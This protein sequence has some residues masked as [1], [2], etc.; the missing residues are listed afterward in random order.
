MS[1][2]GG[3]EGRRRVLFVHGPRNVGGDT[4]AILRLIEGLDRDVIDPIVVA[5]PAGAAWARFVEL[6]GAGRVRLHALEMGVA[7]TEHEAPAVSTGTQARVVATRS[8]LFDQ[9]VANVIDY[10]T[11]FCQSRLLLGL[12]YLADM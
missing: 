5:S 2:V 4:I 8:D 11:D 9:E 7:D 6:A 10:S 12:A 3:A 1:R